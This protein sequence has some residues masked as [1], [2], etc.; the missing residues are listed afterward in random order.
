MKTSI[1]R[2]VG[3]AVIVLL[4][5]NFTV[6]AQKSFYDVKREAG[7]V[8][9]KTKYVMGDFGVYEQESVAK[10]TYDKN[11]DFLKKEVFVWNPRHVWNDKTN[12]YCPDYSESNWTPKYC[13]EQ[14]KNGNLV[15]LE[16]VFW[17]NETQSYGEPKERMIYQLNT[18]DNRLNYLIRQKGDKYVEEINNID[19]N[20]ELFAELTERVG[21]TQK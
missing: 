19:L 7:K 15:S 16:L 21:N 1:L 2:T 5:S 9:S 17:D 20:K 14:E 4:M 13:I 11:G 8:V 18:F 12:R 6:N 3:F 10:Y